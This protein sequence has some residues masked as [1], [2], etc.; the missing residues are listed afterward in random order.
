MLN[1][2]FT[3]RSHTFSIEL[4]INKLTFHKLLKLI[5]GNYFNE[6]TFVKYS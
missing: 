6:I 4:F 2:Q 3:H 5:V 1:P